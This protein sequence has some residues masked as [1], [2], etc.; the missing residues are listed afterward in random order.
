MKYLKLERSDGPDNLSPEHL[1]L[2]GPVCTNWLCKAYN[3]ICDLE[4]IPDCFKHG[5]IVPAFKGKRRDPLRVNS[6]HGITLTSVLA[7]VLEILL[8]NR[9]SVILGDS[10]VPQLTQMAYIRN[11][12]CPD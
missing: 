2:C 7:K 4:Q 11:V 3:S 9:T 1:R 6:Y 5:I 10:E 12:G 8:L